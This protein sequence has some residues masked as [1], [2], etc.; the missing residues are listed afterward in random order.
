MK[1]LLF[2]LTA[3]TSILSHAIHLCAQ[4]DELDAMLEMGLGELVELEVFTASRKHQRISAAPANIIVI[5]SETIERRG[6]RTL[7]EVLRDLPGFDFTTSQ[8]AGEYP[9]HFIFRGITDVGQ[10]N[11]LVMVD[12]I[13]RNDISNDWA[14][15]LGYN[16]PL[17]DV[18]KIEVVSGPGSVLYGANAYAGVINI[19]TKTADGLFENEAKT[20]SVLDL[21]NTYGVDQ[22][23][24]PEIFVG[25]KFQNGLTAQL[26]GRW[27]KT[28]GDGGLD[29]PDP[30]NYFHNNY[31][32]DV[33]LTTEF[34]DIPNERNPDGRTRRIP[35]GF[36]TGINDIT[37]RGRI[38]KGGFTLGFTHWDKEE[39]LGSYVPGYEYFA[40]TEGLDYLVHHAGNTVFASYEFDFNE[41]LLSQSRFYFRNTRILPETGFTYTYKY[42][43]VDNGVNP[44]VTDKKKGYHAEGFIIGLEEQA[45]IRLSKESDL[46]L[47]LQLEQQIKQPLGISLGPEQDATSTIV[48][49]TYTSE[50]QTVQP[51][52]FFHH[53]ALFAQ[54]E[55]RI[56]ENYRLT[57]GLRYDT[58]DEYGDI[59]NPR[60]AFVTTPVK[61]LSLKLLYGQ[62]YKAPTIFELFDEFRGNPELAP[63]EIAT[64]E[65]ELGYAFPKYAAVKVNYFYSRLTDLI[66][67]AP[68]PDPTKVPIGPNSERLDYFQNIG[69]THISGLVLSSD[70]RLGQDVSSYANYTYTRGEDGATIDNIAQHK[71]NFGVNYLLLHRLNVNLRANWTGKV[72][73]P[74]SNRYFHPRDSTSVAEVGYDYVTEDN[75]DGY[76]DGH[77]LLHMTL[78]GVKL[79]AIAS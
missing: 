33:I 50:E 74:V 76:M 4:D 30:G 58:S 2:M 65:I 53:L 46:I 36:K 61:G 1:R 5:T 42:Q 75:P 40:N 67:V 6:Y 26:A 9:T 55:Q 3:I 24:A 78:T 52:F 45:N 34:G 56:G 18:E 73:A 31:E 44:P 11:V 20:R 41:R 21:K 59:L 51:M 63:Q 47:G 49:S 68:N 15:Y 79:R 66:V 69:S 23:I 70:F 12:G 16:L 64:S 54:A 13:V 72:K 35:D 14:M 48:G 38:Q 77:V 37:L 17:S 22:T 28:D 27:Y 19:I 57:G 39:G 8:P 71:A 32:P 62:A 25:Y 60:F 29:R 43:S 10:T 7:E